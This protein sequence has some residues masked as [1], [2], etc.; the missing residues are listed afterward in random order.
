M[1]P[2]RPR[3]QSIHPPTYLYPISPAHEAPIPGP[4][5]SPNPITGWDLKI[6]TLHSN[7]GWRFANALPNI[8]PPNLTS[9]SLQ[10]LLSSG[11]LL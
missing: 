1:S 11:S 7:Q 5:L 3:P 6:T 9:H 2:A 8:P 4:F 10:K